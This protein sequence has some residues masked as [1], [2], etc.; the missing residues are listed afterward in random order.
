MYNEYISHCVS[1]A[2]DCNCEEL[3]DSILSMQSRT[4]GEELTVGIIGNEF[5]IPVILRS[6]L[7][8]LEVGYVSRSFRLE[9]EWGEKTECFQFRPENEE[10]CVSQDRLRDALL[11]ESLLDEDDSSYRAPFCGRITMTAEPLKGLRLILIVSVHDFEDF[12]WE[13]LL[14]ELDLCCVVLSASKLLSQAERELARNRLEGKSLMYLLTGMEQVQE[15]DREKVMEVLCSFTGGAR[16]EVLD[17]PEKFSGLWEIWRAVLPTLPE[18]KMARM[19]LVCAYG[20]RKLASVL[21][22]QKKLV[23]MDGAEVGRIIRNLSRAYQDLPNR[24]GR[25][26]RYIHRC[27]EELKTNV[28]LELVHFNVEFRQHLKEGIDEEPDIRR[29]Q[30]ALSGFVAGSWE[31]FWKENCE[32]K[33]RDQ[34]DKMDQLIQEHIYQQLESLLKQY[35]TVEEYQELELILRD[36]Y[37]A[38]EPAGIRYSG[39][40]PNQTSEGL[41]AFSR[42]LPGCFFV[43][44]GLA[45]LSNL[46]LPGLALVLAG[47]DMRGK[48]S[49]EQKEQIYADGTAM[50]DQCLTKL[51]EQMETGFKTIEQDMCRTVE[52]H[53]D[54]VMNQLV[55]ILERYKADD[56]SNRKQIDQ[57]EAALAL[58]NSDPEQAR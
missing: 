44:G 9:V 37:D 8:E 47:W 29:L 13:E 25:T 19:E 35:L 36:R 18:A 12:A 56:E 38:A 30:E 1:L 7:P 49:A 43:V 23:Q 15:A 20:R 21:E 57:I 10:S 54:H 48:L 2:R 32:P 33:L 31:E 11:A 26:V 52:E 42:L 4:Q 6:L 14:P 34:A 17:T 41:G 3:A 45:L 50:S 51:Q 46:F 28:N 24:K 39:V 16:T 5:T 22:D 55:S 40:T 53:Y 58:L 27:L